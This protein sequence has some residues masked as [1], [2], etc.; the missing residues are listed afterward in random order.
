MNIYKST[1]MEIVKR[2]WAQF[3]EIRTC[4]C[5]SIYGHVDMLVSPH[6]ELRAIQCGH[7][8][9]STDDCVMMVITVQYVESLSRNLGCIF[10]HVFS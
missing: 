10:S 4:V 8:G 5:Q 2:A 9:M 3:V 6:M 7:V 1:K